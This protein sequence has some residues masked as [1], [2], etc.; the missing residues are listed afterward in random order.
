MVHGVRWSISNFIILFIANQ[1][2]HH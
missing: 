2:N 1:P